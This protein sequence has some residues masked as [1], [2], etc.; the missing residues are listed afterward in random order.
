MR[1]LIA[2]LVL[3]CTTLIVPLAFADEPPLEPDA[4]VADAQKD[5]AEERATQFVG[6]RGPD[7]E[8]VPGGAL[9]LTAYA[10]VWGL[11]F[12]FLMRM[13]RLQSQTAEELERLSAEIRASGDH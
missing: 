6:V 11:L 5:A 12:L 4:A 13:R 2:A 10:I 8:S 7:A 1:A 9:L 3:G